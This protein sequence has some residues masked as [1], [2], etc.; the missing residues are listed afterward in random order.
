MSFDRG[1]DEGGMVHLHD[2]T[3]LSPKKRRNTAIRNNVMDLENMTLR[4]TSQSEKSKDH[5]ISLICGM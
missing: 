1:V 5:L 2:G 3:L 4:E